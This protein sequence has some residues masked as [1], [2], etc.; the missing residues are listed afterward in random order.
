M[1]IQAGR[2]ERH[3]W[4]DLWRYRELFYQLAWRDLLVRYKQP[5][6]GIAWAVLRPV[7]TMVIFSV[8]F[9]KMGNFPSNGVPYPLL[10]FAALLPWQLF[11]SS[12]SDAGNSLVGNAHLISKVYFPRLIIPAT[13][14]IVSLVD[15]GFSILVMGGLMIG[16]GWMP[17]AS[18]L[19]LP[20]FIFA[21]LLV[22]LGPGLLITALTVKYRDFRYITPFIVQVGLFASPVAYSSTMVREKFGELPYH[23]YCLNPMVGVI[24]GFRWALLGPS[25]AV[26]WSG[27]A[28][29][30]GISGILLATGIWYF[31]RTERRFADVI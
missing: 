3:Y 13:S 14:L 7:I 30:F 21:A 20:L 5:T 29:S 27:F 8:L 24:D 18:V 10:V 11:A 17:G 15:F 9:G 6:L 28:V 16:Y 23:L 1:I 19:L 4:R 12:L 31:R 25:F 22:A 26:N 2:T